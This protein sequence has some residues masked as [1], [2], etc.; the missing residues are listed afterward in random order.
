MIMPSEAFQHLSDPE[1][2]ALVALIRRL[3]RGGTEAPHNRYGPMGRI[4]IAIGK[5]K[6]A[7]VLVAEYATK[8]PLRVGPPYEVGR[9]LAV[10]KCSGCHAADLTGQEIGPSEKSPDLTIAG[11]YDLDAFK[12]LL[13]TGIPAGGQKLPMM[14]PTAR[15]DLSHLT[16][17]EIGQLQAYLVARA[18]RLS[19]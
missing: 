9:R 2:A 19:R 12:T 10:L 6:T 3:P 13:R 14:G 7:P 16:D 18:Q 8:E 4:G 5:F 15:S 17:A 1:S 11:A